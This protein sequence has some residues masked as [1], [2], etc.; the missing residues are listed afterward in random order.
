M[1]LL[2]WDDSGGGSSR[3][4][5]GK[6]EFKVTESGGSERFARFVER[7]SLALGAAVEVREVVPRVPAD[8]RVY[9]LIFANKPQLGFVTG[10]TYGLSPLIDSPASGRELCISMR[11][12]DLEWAMVPAITVAALRGLCPFEPGMVIGYK[13]PYVEGSGLSSLL[14]GT[15]ESRLMMDRR[16]DLGVLP[17]RDADDFVELVGAYPIYPSERNFFHT[18]GAEMAWN[19]E[20]DPTDPI[21]SALV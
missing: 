14:L 8:G 20:W 4:L 17:G 12:D 3:S 1:I 9:S 19:S 7:L 6:L 10:I 18:H 11:S 21:R 13:K 15:P 2:E 5:Q 16:I